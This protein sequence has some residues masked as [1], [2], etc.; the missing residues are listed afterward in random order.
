MHEDRDSARAGQCGWPDSTR[1]GSLEVRIRRIDIEDLGKRYRQNLHGSLGNPGQVLSFIGHFPFTRW[2]IFPS[3]DA[4]SYYG[5]MG[6]VNLIL[7]I[8]YIV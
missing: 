3:P 1:L 4:D 7:N 8:I 5:V 6:Y 2:D